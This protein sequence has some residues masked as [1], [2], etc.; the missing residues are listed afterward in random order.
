MTKKLI[1]QIKLFSTKSRTPLRKPTGTEGGRTRDS[2]HSTTGRRPPCSCRTSHDSQTWRDAD[3]PADPGTS[4]SSPAA[5]SR[6]APLVAG[7]P[8]SSKK[9]TGD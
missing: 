2:D 8:G 1:H 9:N 5:N 7:S 3:T 4:V 6:V